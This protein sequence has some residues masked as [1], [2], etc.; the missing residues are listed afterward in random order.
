ME[1]LKR[2]EMPKESFPMAV[3]RSMGYP[4]FRRR[5]G[6]PHG[7]ENL[8]VKAEKVYIDPLHQEV[9]FCTSCGYQAVDKVPRSDGLPYPDSGT[10]RTELECVVPY[11]AHYRVLMKVTV[12]G[13]VTAR[14]VSAIPEAACV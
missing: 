9:A 7:V 13:A 14:I 2:A 8:T 5:R 6:I 11:A 10:V 3:I 12:N 4:F 1:E